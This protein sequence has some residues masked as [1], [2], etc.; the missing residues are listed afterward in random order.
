MVR[1]INGNEHRKCPRCGG[2]G[3]LENTAVMDGKCFLCDGYG[4]DYLARDIRKAMEV[5]TNEK[6]IKE[7]KEQVAIKYNQ[8]NSTK[9]EKRK[10]WYRSEAKQ[11]FNILKKQFNYVMTLEEIKELANKIN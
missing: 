9:S 1:S 3:Y 6:W 4:N 8:V 10:Q 2:K 7:L 5:K 11:Y